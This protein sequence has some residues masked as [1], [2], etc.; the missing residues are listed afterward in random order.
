MCGAPWRRVLGEEAAQ[1]AWRQTCACAALPAV[2]CRVL[3][4]FAGSCTTGVVCIEEGR[5]FT[6]L[7]LNPDY[8]RLGQARLDDAWQR[9]Q[10][11]HA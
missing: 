11:A 10:V 4:P 6:G 5:A 8:A 3:D 7:E 2:P 9:K 1:D